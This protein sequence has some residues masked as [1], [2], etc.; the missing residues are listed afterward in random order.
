MRT[1]TNWRRIP[2]PTAAGKVWRRRQPNLGRRAGA[3]AEF[4]PRQPEK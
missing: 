4:G 2:P 1:L 3:P